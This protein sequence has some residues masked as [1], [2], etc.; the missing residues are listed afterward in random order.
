MICCRSTVFNPVV[1]ACFFKRFRAELTTLICYDDFRCS[2]TTDPFF[3]EDLDYSFRQDISDWNSSAQ[4]V[5]ISI[6]VNMIDLPE[7]GGSGPTI[8]R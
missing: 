6:I 5:C 3:V 2:K 4:E 1:H 8:S 7:I